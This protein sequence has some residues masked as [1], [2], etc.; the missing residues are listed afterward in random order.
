MAQAET[1]KTHPDGLW[2]EPKSSD[3]HHRFRSIVGVRS[4]LH[5]TY[6]QQD[7]AQTVSQG[8]QKYQ[9]KRIT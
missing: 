7:V 4:Y 9:V 6:Q 8:L 1:E 2:G 5:T 3:F